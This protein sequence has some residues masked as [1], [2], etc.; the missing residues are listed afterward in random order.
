MNAYT[1]FKCIQMYCMKAEQIY[2]ITF[3]NTH[4]SSPLPRRN[5]N[6]RRKHDTTLSRL[7]VRSLL[8]HPEHNPKHIAS[9]LIHKKRT[10]VT[11]L[12]QQLTPPHRRHAHTRSEIPMP[13]LEHG[14]TIFITSADMSSQH[15]YIP[16]TSRA[17]V[18][19]VPP[20]ARENL[21]LTSIA[22]AIVERCIYIYLSAEFLVNAVFIF[23]HTARRS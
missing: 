21:F 10:K 3:S 23:I 7:P 9:H 22:T 1:L 14:I 11:S 13:L 19:I 12:G 4:T 6:K 5:S 18:Y 8:P 16:I 20:I 15:I 2:S 17:P